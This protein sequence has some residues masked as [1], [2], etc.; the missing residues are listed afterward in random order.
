M[1]RTNARRQNPITWR[2]TAFSGNILSASLAAGGTVVGALLSPITNA[3]DAST[4]LSGTILGGTI[5]MMID[6]V[7]A[8]QGGFIEYA[9]LLLDPGVANPSA[10]TDATKAQYE[11]YVWYTGLLDPHPSNDAQA[12]LRLRLGTKRRF[13]KGTNLVLVFK[14]QGQAAWGAT[15]QFVFIADLYILED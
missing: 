6:T 12:I 9:V 15:N 10:W 14:N 13:V 2:P 1:V 8:R 11:K 7:V 4:K 3:S 5:D